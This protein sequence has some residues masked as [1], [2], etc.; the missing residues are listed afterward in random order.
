MRYLELI[1]RYGPT[2]SVVQHG[3][4]SLRRVTGEIT[5]D[6]VFRLGPAVHRLAS[7]RALAMWGDAPSQVSGEKAVVLVHELSV[8]IK[9][10][11]NRISALAEYVNASTVFAL[12]NPSVGLDDTDFR[13]NAS[14][15][16]RFDIFYEG[17]Q[18]YAVGNPLTGHAVRLERLPE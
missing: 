12:M 2:G 15:G 9:D 3:D 6:G 17:S 14:A 7:D 1:F 8:T 13:F 11:E 4:H 18:P 16:R 5:S 10:A